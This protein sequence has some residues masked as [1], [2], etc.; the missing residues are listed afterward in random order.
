MD[1]FLEGL[2]REAGVKPGDFFPVMVGD[3]TTD[4]G[5]VN[6]AVHLGGLGYWVGNPPPGLDPGAGRLRNT[7]SVWALLKRLREALETGKNP[8]E[9]LTRPLTTRE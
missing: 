7:D 1:F 4:L 5:A 6:H 2:A 9:V 3:D 8:L